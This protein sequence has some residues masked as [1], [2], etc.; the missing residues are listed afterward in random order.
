VGPAVPARRR[1]FAVVGRFRNYSESRCELNPI[2]PLGPV[3]M[4]HNLPP[5]LQNKWNALLRERRQSL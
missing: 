4:G 1:S 5:A 2:G 3:V